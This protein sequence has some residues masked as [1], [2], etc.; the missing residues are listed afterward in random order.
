[1]IILVITKPGATLRWILILV[2]GPRP[3]WISRLER[4]P[5]K[6]WC[7]RIIIKVYCLQCL[8]LRGFVINVFCN[9]LEYCLPFVFIFYTVWKK[10]RHGAPRENFPRGPAISLGGP[11]SSRVPFLKHQR[12]FFRNIIFVERTA[13]T[14]SIVFCFQNF[15]VGRFMSCISIIEKSF[16]KFYESCRCV[17]RSSQGN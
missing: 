12:V 15:T 3:D 9:A 13:Y 14:A 11:S 4:G 6:L 7:N 17:S 10:R 2:L 5:V 1:M 16:G 8:K